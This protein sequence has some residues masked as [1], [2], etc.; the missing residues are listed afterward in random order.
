M[1]NITEIFHQVEFE[2]AAPSN[3]TWWGGHLF[4]GILNM[5]L[6]VNKLRYAYV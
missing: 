4:D 1:Y 2:L 5:F 6:K 3:S